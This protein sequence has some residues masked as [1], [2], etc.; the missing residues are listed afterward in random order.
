[1]AVRKLGEGLVPFKEPPYRP[2]CGLPKVAHL[3]A[4]AAAS[5]LKLLL[6]LTAFGPMLMYLG[7]K[8]LKLLFVTSRGSL[9]SSR[10]KPL[11]VDRQTV[12]EVWADNTERSEEPAE[13]GKVADVNILLI[14]FLPTPLEAV[15]LL[16][17]T[18]LL[19]ALVVQASESQ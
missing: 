6:P 3:F 11:P 2:P 13:R 9:S 19:P 16:S 18:L 12:F 5:T 4:V 17:R 14:E 8:R 1:M 10:S 15:M 7:S